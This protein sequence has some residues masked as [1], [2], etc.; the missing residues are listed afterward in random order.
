MARRTLTAL[1][2][3][4][5][6]ART[7]AVAHSALQLFFFALAISLSA[8]PA[9]LAQQVR[10]PAARQPDTAAWPLFDS[11]APLELTLAVPFRELR[12]TTRSR[13]E[14]DGQVSYVDAAGNA[15]ELDVEV[16]VRGNSR[17]EQCSFP[18]LRLDFKRRQL[19]GTV[20]A[21]QNRLKLV[22]LCERRDTYRDY[23]ALE[24]DTYR[25][26]AVLTER[27]YRV[28]PATV[29]Y[30]TTDARREESFTESAFLIETDIEA[31]ARLGTEVIEREQ[32][33]LDELHREHTA[34]LGVFQY[35][36][37]NNDWSPLRGAAGE[38]CCH[39]GNVIGPIEGG[40]VVLPYDFD[41]S[42]IIDADYVTPNPQLPI[43][44]IT[45]RLY[46]GYCEFNP[47]AEAA[48]ATVLSRS[49]ELE[50]V[51]AQGSTRERAKERAIEFLRN[52]LAHL[53]DTQA[54]TK[55]I[56]EQCRG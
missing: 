56:I 49:A 55:E 39:N 46:R 42:G 52:S 16:R 20:F 5:Q 1:S 18:P 36:I 35:I 3:P 10:Q 22:T 37:A 44:R 53:A 50:A 48:I 23:L 29:Q 40:I 24:Y 33:S 6:R 51:L 2:T 21:G 32:I 31:A 34:L 45:Q 14:L 41:R 8:A 15:V 12:R 30:R 17:L 54:R 7:T 4:V 11:S 9:A 38:D 43:R 19:D 13:E 28:R 25:L 47:E 27:A 26:F